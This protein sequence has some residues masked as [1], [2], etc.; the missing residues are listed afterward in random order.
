MTTERY[1][2]TQPGTLMRVTLGLIMGLQ[3]LWLVYLTVRFNP[4]GFSVACAMLVVFSVCLLLF[5]SLTVTVDDETLE[6]RFGPG[7]IRKRYPL[8][9]LVSCE[10]V[11]Y[12]WLHG[13]GIHKTWQGWDYNVS[14]LDAVE[15]VL[16]SG[17]KDRIGTDAPQE[18]AAALK[19]RIRIGGGRES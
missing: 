16:K 6:I 4:V 5:H 11:R 15:V 18:L 14:G 19:E 8:G 13:C 17:R 1:E 9:E 3:F 2:H 12:S 7:L 10:V